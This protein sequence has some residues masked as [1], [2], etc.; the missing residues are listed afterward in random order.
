M[1][2]PFIKQITP[3]LRVKDAAAA[4]EFYRCA[5]GAVEHFRLTEPGSG[6][7]GHAELGL[8]A[9]TL[10]ISDE[11]PEY[12]IQGPQAFGGTGSA[13]HLQVGDVDAMVAQAVE[14]GASLL[15]EP[16]DQFYGERSAKLLDPFGHEWM[17]STR[18]EEVGP[19]EMQ[20]RFEA[21]FTES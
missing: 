10:M 19:E 11:Y 1:S 16:Q 15:M 20:R 12:G 17:L 14:M 21:L 9:S 7:V 2:K 4:I 6:R 5:F 13:V 18:I 3:Y 8:G